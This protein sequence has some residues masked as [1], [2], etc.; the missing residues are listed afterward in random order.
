MTYLKDLKNN[1]ECT[2]KKLNSSNLEKILKVFGIRKPGSEY[3]KKIQKILNSYTEDFK[4]F[5]CYKQSR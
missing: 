5:F 2:N 1:K 4:V 3:K